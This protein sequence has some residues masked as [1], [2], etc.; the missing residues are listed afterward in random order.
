MCLSSFQYV[1]VIWEAVFMHALIY[2]NPTYLHK[3]IPVLLQKV[4]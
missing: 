2:M 3:L 4:Y 1:K